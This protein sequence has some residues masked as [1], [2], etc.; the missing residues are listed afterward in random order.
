LFASLAGLPLAAQPSG[1]DSSGNKLLSGTYYF[2]QVIYQLSNQGNGSLADA[3]SLYGTI[4]FNGSGGYTMAATLVELANGQVQQGNLTGTYTIAASGQGFLSNP[5]FQGDFIYGLVNAQGIFTGSS[6]EN[7]TGYHDMFI[8]AQLAS[9]LPTAS[10]FRGSYSMAQLDLSN[11]SPQY[12]I[13]LSASMS[14]DGNGNLGT[15][16]LNG[17]LGGNGSSKIV[18]SIGSVKYIFSGGAAVVTFPNS[19]SNLLVGQYYLYFSPDG[20][21][22]FGGSPVSADMI[23]GVR[24]GTGTPSLSGLYYETGMDED[25]STLNSGYA[26]IDTYYGAFNAGGGNITGH[27]RLLSFFNN[28]PVHYTY[29]DTY[30]LAANGT[31]NNGATNYIVGADGIRIASGIGPYLSLS[32]AFPA[33]ALNSSLS[34]SGVYL[35]PQGVVNAGSF[36]PFTA[37]VAPGELLTLYGSNLAPGAQVASTVPF[38]TSLNGV[39]V[40]VNGIAAPLYYVTPTQLSAIVPYSVT[41][42]VATIQVNNNGTPSNSVT[43]LVAMTAPG[44]LTQPQ[45]GLGYGDAIHSNGTLVNAAHPAAI[46]ETVSVFLTGLGAVS[47]AISDGSAGPTSPFSNTTNTTTSYIGGTQASVG[48]AGLAPGYAGLYQ[49]NVTVPTGLTAGDNA[50]DVSGPDAYSSVCLIAVGN[51][52]SAAPSAEAEAE[53]RAQ[54]HR[55]VPRALKPG[56][57]RRFRAATIPTIR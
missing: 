27:Q 16:A 6:T 41:T 56:E 45:N 4:N 49:M 15:V 38:P 52:S 23:V 32:V 42:G 24:T 29:S 22:F 8:A 40:T 20:N 12:T 39:Q 46:G 9:P 10:T 19:N 55:V 36:A 35:S 50:L 51:S 17:Y 34:P 26:S 57:A 47:P 31:Y 30:T 37:G 53:G 48:Y 43:S 5:L 1:W 28:N 13:G 21:F 11:G 25:E 18:Q 14:P 33:P 2:R 7:T 3:A 44:V 54:P